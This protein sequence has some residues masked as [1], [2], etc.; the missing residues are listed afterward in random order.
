MRREDVIKDRALQVSLAVKPLI[1]KQ[2]KILKELADI[3]E[4]LYR[5]TKNIDSSYTLTQEIGDTFQALF[6]VLASKFGFEV[7]VH[8]FCDFI[9]SVLKNYFNPGLHLE[10]LKMALEVTKETFEGDEKHD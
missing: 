4:E 1:E 10:T 5:K 7:T 6:I 2:S 8:G 3:A 9:A